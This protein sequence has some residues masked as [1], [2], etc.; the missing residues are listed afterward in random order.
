MKKKKKTRKQK[1]KTKKKQKTYS[2]VDHNT[3]ELHSLDSCEHPNANRRVM[4]R[5]LIETKKIALSQYLREAEFFFLVKVLE[6]VII[7][8]LERI[9]PFKSKKAAFNEPPWVNVP[10]KR[11]FSVASKPWSAGIWS[12]ITFFAIK[13]TVLARTAELNSTRLW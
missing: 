3:V 12:T 4:W 5:D 8:S 6:N 1:Q 2:H 7:T 13:S 10:S 9:M 11:P